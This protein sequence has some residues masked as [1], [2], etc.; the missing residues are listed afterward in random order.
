MKSKLYGALLAAIV[1][2]GCNPAASS[3][4]LEAEWKAEVS[5]RGAP[6]KEETERLIQQGKKPGI[7]DEEMKEVLH[8]MEEVHALAYKNMEQFRQ[9]WNTKHPKQPMPTLAELGM[10]PK[11]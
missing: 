11:L 2:V 9:D 1:L 3:A 7:S 10:K 8:K 4:N 6:F 5:K